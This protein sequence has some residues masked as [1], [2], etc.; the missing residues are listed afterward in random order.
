VSA[1]RN[2]QPFA[3]QPFRGDELTQPDQVAE[4]IIAT[5][6]LSRDTEVTDVTVHHERKIRTSGVADA[7]H[8]SGARVPAEIG[9]EP[10]LLE[11]PQDRFD[12]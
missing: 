6:L 7:G 2:P 11:E 9:I 3:N 8:R 5:L 4:A 10:T 12:A 1:T